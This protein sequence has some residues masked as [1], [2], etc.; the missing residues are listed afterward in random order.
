[1]ETLSGANHYSPEKERYLNK[2]SYDHETQLNI[3]HF[4][5]GRI[6]RELGVSLSF[7]W[8]FGNSD[9]DA[10]DVEVDSSEL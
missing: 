9:V 8:N 2:L 4:S 7:T 1:M 5:V 6:S 3:G 10:V